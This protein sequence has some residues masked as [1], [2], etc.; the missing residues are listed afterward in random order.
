LENLVVIQGNLIESDALRY[1]PAGVPV[2]KFRLTHRSKQIE[3]GGDREVGC[4]IDAV[5]FESEARLLASAKLGA[6]LKIRGFLDRK[7]KTGRALL[8]HASQI[9]FL[10][11]EKS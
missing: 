11:T 8:L 2:L 5:A 4:E 9:E 10:A 6:A 3:A 7:T 1:T